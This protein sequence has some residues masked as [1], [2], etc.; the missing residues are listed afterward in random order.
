V[1]FSV[2]IET[3]YS[4]PN[5]IWNEKPSTRWHDLCNQLHR[6][7]PGLEKLGLSGS[8]AAQIAALASR[9]EKRTLTRDE[10]RSLHCAHG[11][12]HNYYYREAA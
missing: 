5:H 7:D 4:Y 2:S 9:E 11:E 3:L 10:L 8:R 12:L 1:P 6:Y